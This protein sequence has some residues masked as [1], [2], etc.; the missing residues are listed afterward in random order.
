MIINPITNKNGPTY[1]EKANH[2]IDASC[3]S[4]FNYMHLP[5]EIKCDR[6]YISINK[7]IEKFD[8]II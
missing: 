4:G 7:D 5:K 2:I 1:L 6:K 8:E 3:F